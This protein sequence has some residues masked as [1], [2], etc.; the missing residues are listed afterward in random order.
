MFKV[1]AKELNVERKRYLVLHMKDRALYVL[2][3]SN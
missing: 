2:R 3:T 1:I